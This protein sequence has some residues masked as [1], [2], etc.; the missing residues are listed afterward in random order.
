M[1]LGD[2]AAVWC[3]FCKA[4]F[5]ALVRPGELA[6][7]ACSAPL[8]LGMIEQASA[9]PLPLLQYPTGQIVEVLK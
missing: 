2:T 6:C 7:P 8:K 5:L 3:P 1:K 9:A 4:M